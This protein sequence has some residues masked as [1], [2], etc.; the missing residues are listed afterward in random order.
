MVYHQYIMNQTTP[1]I[2]ENPEIQGINRLPMH[3]NFL[4]FASAE[5]ALLYA[6]EG[7]E[8]SGLEDNALCLSLDG[9]WQ[10]K[11][12]DNPDKDSLDWTKPSGKTADWDTIKVPGTWTRQGGDSKNPFDKPHYTNV[13]MPFQATPP[14]A[15]EHN[16]TGLYRKSFTL[17]Q[18]WKGRR[19]VLHVGSA[20]SCC[21]VYVNGAF[22]GAGKDT[23][24]P[25]EYDI[26]PFLHETGKD[27][28][29]GGEPGDE[30]ILCL[31]VVRYS[32]ASYVEDQ[33]Q[34]WYG[35]IHRSV[36]LYSTPDCYIQDAAAIPG[37][38]R[39]GR[40]GRTE[41]V[42]RLSVTLGGDVP[43]GRSTGN[44]AVNVSADAKPFAI[45]Y[46]LY[47]FSRPG[48]RED[49]EGITA[50][51]KPLVSGET[52]LTCNYR[53][54]SNRAE[55]ELVLKNPKLWSH[56]EPNLYVIEVSVFREGKH[57][58][59][60]AFTTAF[61]TVCVANR[62][63]LINGKAVLIKGVNRHEHDEK[64][65]KTLSMESMIRDI[66]LLKQ[67]NFNAVRT[68][69]YPDDER[70]YDLCDRY[71]IYL[72]DEANIENHC[73]YNQIADDPAWTYA[74]TARV[75]RMVERDKNHPSIILWSLGNES[76]D[77]ASHAACSAWVHRRDPSRPVNYE[78]AVRPKGGQGAFTLDSLGLGKDITDIIGPMYPPIDLISDFAKYR[79]DH[80]PLIMIEYSHAMGNS[81]G[82]L[83]DYWKAIES[84][85]GLQG[86]FIWEWIDHG[87]EAFTPD[88][89]K[90][91]K[92]GGDFGDEPT[93]YDFCCDGLILPDQTLK[94]G[95]AEC[96]QVFA[97]VR[98][99][100]IPGKPYSITVEN[101][102][103]FSGLKAIGFHW[104]LR[105]RDAILAEGRISLPDLAPG[106]SAEIAL[107]VPKNSA[108]Q[109]DGGTFYLHGDFYLKQDTP[110]AQ[111]GFIIGSGERIIRESLPLLPPKNSAGAGVNPPQKTKA[112]AVSAA[113]ATPAAVSALR[114]FAA[115]FKPSLF[116]VPTQNDG[117][118]TCGHLRGDPAAEFY[119]RNKAL[120]P[121]LDLDL[122]HLRCTKEKTE[123]ISCEG[124]PAVRY[125]TVLLAGENAA[126]GFKN[127]RLGTYTCII[128]PFV[129][130]LTS[131]AGET[132]SIPPAPESLVMDI[133]F[134]L[135]PALPEL[136]KVGI[137][138][139]IPAGYSDISWFGLGPEESYP[140]RMAGVFLGSYR[141][142]VA[143]LEVPYIM[144][145]ENGNRSGVRSITLSGKTA[146]DAAI[147]ILPD[148]PVNMSCSRYTQENMLSALH[149]C[150]LVDVSVGKDGYYML[151]IDIAQR[152]VGTATCGPDTLEQYRIRGG[153]FKLQLHITGR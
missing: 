112:A 57:I 116:R 32:D 132:Q 9:K 78:G 147:T 85:H 43:E 70:W 35:G 6:I 46:A 20:E 40:G 3:G 13:Q 58:E 91:W 93:D 73:F 130:G 110:W 87:L 81:N 102:F 26:T 68:C 45:K 135:D 1:P 124:G 29:G 33:D 16:P 92:Y 76:G 90:Y 141:N 59:S 15:P 95:M 74:Y 71:G 113:A 62:E 126:R 117:L 83:A 103:D 50:K 122:L 109:Q 143:E 54:N 82:S 64:T 24:L 18:K 107:G 10:F 153:V 118:K 152:G 72:V 39:E 34:W 23:R 77:G 148:K 65:G 42:L 11:L 150:D 5:K 128:G 79:D 140:D 138:A 17:P 36:Y 21:L 108:P 51:L 22:V 115:L 27:K 86:G 28:A 98:F 142:T 101:R 63:L 48:S 66:M 4:P 52:E 134:D 2:W 47:P 120:Y 123:N 7:P 60:A 111:A 14:H 38:L 53:L 94:P 67:H 19:V 25:S 151:N 80:R 84:H 49:A 114:E 125:T 131:A 75:Q 61:R 56:E 145:Q 105:T 146:R 119:Y 89:R 96:K 129:S 133:V 100:S 97:P 139:K 31:K 69:H 144:P 121:W 127:T 41:G 99:K 149:T 137:T 136:P 55:V 88:G 12:L 104:Q 37:G 8:L 44:T 106:A 30:N